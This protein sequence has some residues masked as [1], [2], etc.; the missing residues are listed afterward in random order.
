MASISTPPTGFGNAFH[1]V[2]T[3]TELISN[4]CLFICINNIKQCG[5]RLT[6]QKGMFQRLRPGRFGS[7]V[8]FM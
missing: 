2:Y 1:L 7:V 6:E 5:S 8:V 3:A 4:A